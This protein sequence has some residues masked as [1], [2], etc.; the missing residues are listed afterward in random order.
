MERDLSKEYEE[1]ART[2]V[3]PEEDEERSFIDYYRSL[4]KVMRMPNSEIIKNG[5]LE[6]S[7]FY[8]ILKGNR[9]PGRDKVIR[10]CLGAGLTVEETS[11]ALILNENAPLYLKKKRDRILAFAVKKGLSVTE[12]NLLLDEKGEQ[13]LL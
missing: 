6:K 10:L 5:D 11:Q 4:E 7:Y 1:F 13:P 2:S 8:Q 3:R 9:I 12:T